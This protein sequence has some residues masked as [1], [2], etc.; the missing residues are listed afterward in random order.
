MGGVTITHCAPGVARRLHRLARGGGDDP[1]HHRHGARR[2]LL[3]GL[4][5]LSELLRLQRMPFAGRAADADA[6]HAERDVV[7]D[8]ALQ[9]RK[10]QLLVLG[11][12]R[13]D[14]REN[15]DHVLFRQQLRHSVFL[16]KA[17][18]ALP[19]AIFSST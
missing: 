2:R 12:G 15:T 7:V 3:R 16:S 10:V 19:P 14:G 11:E 9:R 18:I 4:D 1:R 6:R 17:E 5:D 13:H 8:L